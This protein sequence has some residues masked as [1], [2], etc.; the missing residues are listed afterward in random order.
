LEEA[1]LLE[2]ATLAELEAEFHARVQQME[3]QS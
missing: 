3:F 1:A 2:E